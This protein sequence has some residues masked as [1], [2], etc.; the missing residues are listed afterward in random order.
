MITALFKAIL[1]KLFPSLSYKGVVNKQIKLYQRSINKGVPEQ[2]A[3]NQLLDSRRRALKITN[4]VVS[5]TQ[6]LGANE[7]YQDLI[8]LPNKTLAQTIK[9]IVEWEYLYNMKSYE[10]R[11]KNR[12]PP[13]N[14]DDFKNEVSKYIES[15]VVELKF[16]R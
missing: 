8:M 11:N 5:N 10:L 13:S 12:I 1:I 2:D 7:Y 9:A 4:S 3:L 14:V 6:D 16:K 15:K